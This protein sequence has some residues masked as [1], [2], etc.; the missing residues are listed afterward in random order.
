MPLPS[1]WPRTF[2]EE[3][4]PQEYEE[5]PSLLK[6]YFADEPNP[7][8]FAMTRALEERLEAT[9]TRIRRN[10]AISEEKS[11]LLNRGFYCA[12]ISFAANLALLAIRLF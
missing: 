4:A 1:F 10:T 6:I 11:N 7:E 2:L 8:E 5:M 3:A 9:H 12:V